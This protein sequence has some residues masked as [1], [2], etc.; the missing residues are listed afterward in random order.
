MPAQTAETT[1]HRVSAAQAFLRASAHFGVAVNAIS[2]LAD[3]TELSPTFAKQQG[4]WDSFVANGS[5]EVERV[6][7][8]YEAGTLP[9]YFFRPDS[10]LSTGKTL[11]AVNG[12]D[13]SLA[14]LWAACVSAALKRG[15]SVLVFDGPGQQSQLF[16]HGIP[17]RTDW[18]NVLTPVYDFVAGLAGIDPTHI[19]L[20]GISQGGYWVPRALA[21]EHRYAAAIADPGVV[22][23]S[24]SWTGHL[25]KSLTKLLDEGKN[26]KF[27]KEM[28][29]GMKF[30]PET[31]RTWQFRARAPETRSSR[32]KS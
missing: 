22:D 5:V 2:A 29:L 15:Y 23:V 11:V 14:A 27:D 8:P 30:S 12:S 19:A 31:A 6:G 17:F 4:A 28:A 20:Y 10:T 9:G 16:D 3:T 7:I 13:G 18:E 26:E 21:F 24:T 32:A 1:G 25:P